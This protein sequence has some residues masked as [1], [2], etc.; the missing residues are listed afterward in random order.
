MKIENLLILCGTALLAVLIFSGTQCSI[1][2]TEATSEC[3]KAGKAPLECQRAF[4][5]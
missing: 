3:I 4:V 1:R 2:N 5:N